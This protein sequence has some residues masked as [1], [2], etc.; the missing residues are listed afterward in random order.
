[1]PFVSEKLRILYIERVC[2]LF[3]LSFLPL[4]FVFEF[5]F[6]SFSFSD[7]FSFF[8]L[9]LF[10]TS[11]LH[12]LRTCFK[13]PLV[14]YEEFSGCAA[15]FQMNCKEEKRKRKKK[16]EEDEKK[17]EKRNLLEVEVEQSGETLYCL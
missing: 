3:S 13:I 7:F 2:V 14:K 9:F 1:M 6:F 8:F 5:F 10:L 17:E 11:H 12:L 16:K 4:C 15:L